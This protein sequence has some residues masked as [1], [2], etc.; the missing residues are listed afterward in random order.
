MGWMTSIQFLAGAAIFLFA[1]VFRVCPT[2]YSFPW[3]EADHSPS[4]IAKVKGV[5]GYISTSP[6]VFLY[7]KHRNVTFNGYKR[8]MV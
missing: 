6:Y 4:F 8:S 2:L 5:S 1:M 3:G 7:F